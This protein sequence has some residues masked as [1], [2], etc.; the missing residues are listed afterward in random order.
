MSAIVGQR[1][2]QENSPYAPRLPRRHKSAAPFVYKHHPHRWQFMQ[3]SGEW[4]PLLSKMKIDPGVGGVDD[5]RGTDLAVA[6]NTRRGWQIIRPADERL[7]DFRW[8]VQRIPKAGKGSVHC[9]ASESVEV[10]GGRAFWTEGGERYTQFLRHLVSAG[11]VAPVSDQVKRLKMEQQRATV[12]RLESSVAHAPHNQV[13]SA[14][15]DTARKG[16]DAM[17]TP[18]PKRRKTPKPPAQDTPA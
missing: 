7:G 9:D 6:Q 17:A 14:R 8:Y 16:L 18:K 5:N 13:I 11:I 1:V 3:D 15:L 10:I 2:T 12:D 4:L